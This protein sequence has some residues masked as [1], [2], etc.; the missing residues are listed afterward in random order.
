MFKKRIRSFGKVQFFIGKSKSRS[1]VHV[2]YERNFLRPR[3]RLPVEEDQVNGE[4]I[5]FENVSIR[6]FYL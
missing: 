1:L 2:R 3:I 4:I 6:I 5:I